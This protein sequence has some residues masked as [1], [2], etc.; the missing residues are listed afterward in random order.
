[1]GEPD[2]QVH[3]FRDADGEWRW[4]R[5]TSDSTIVSGSEQGYANKED[6]K[7]IAAHLNPDVEIVEDQ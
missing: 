1:M 6:A 4:Y 7:A 5:I 2:D 3:L